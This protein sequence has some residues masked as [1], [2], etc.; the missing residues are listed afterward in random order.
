MVKTC[1][2]YARVSTTSQTTENQLL[3]LRAT[4]QRMGWKIVAELVDE[5]N[6]GSKGKEER[7]AFERLHH[8]IQRRECDVVMVWSI[9]Q[10]GRSMTHLVQLMDA[11][12][13][14][15]I[16]LF[17]EKQA[18]NTATPAGRMVF[19]IFSALAEFEREIICERVKSGIAR[20]KANGIKCGRP[21]NV[22]D[23]VRSAVRL[24]REQGKPIRQIARTLNIGVGTTYNIL[25]TA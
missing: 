11:L 22:N 19:G 24:L 8:M 17:A 6:S 9:D 15:G 7:P 23:S 1:I 21:S 2:L 12:Q 13:A 10:L 14:V 25:S 4:A 20:A 5:G 18:L 16:D 3:T